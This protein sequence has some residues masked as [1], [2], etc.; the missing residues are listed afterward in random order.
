MDKKISEKS[1][2][3]IYDVTTKNF[4]NYIL[5]IN[6]HDDSEVLENI[7]RIV[8]GFYV[9]DWQPVEKDKYLVSLKN[10]SEKLTQSIDDESQNNKILLINGDETVEKSLLDNSDF[11]AIGSTMK[12]NIEE[13]IEEYGESLSEQEKV[14]ILVDILKKYL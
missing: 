14:N 1:K 9:E 6:S 12:N 8:T 3:K 11:S 4:M 5:T 2:L 7:A 13:L 10:I